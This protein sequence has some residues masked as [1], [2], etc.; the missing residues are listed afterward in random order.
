VSKY[1][2]DPQGWYVDHPSPAMVPELNAAELVSGQEFDPAEFGVPG[3]KPSP[4]PHPLFL[5][6]SA[7]VAPVTVPATRAP[8]V[9]DE[10]ASGE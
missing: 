6:L 3:W 5:D 4:Y 7:P 10:H 8:V 2:F 9:T 1:R